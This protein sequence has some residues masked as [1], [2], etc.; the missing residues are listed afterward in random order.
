MFSILFI[1]FVRYTRYYLIIIVLLFSS[2]FEL[3]EYTKANST[4]KNVCVNKSFTSFEIGLSFEY[5]QCSEYGEIYILEYNKGIYA[6]APNA[7]QYLPKVD[8]LFQIHAKYTDEPPIEAIKRTMFKSIDL[9]EQQVC[10]VKNTYTSPNGVALYTIKDR[11][12]LLDAN[13]KHCKYKAYYLDEGFYF[14]PNKNMFFYVGRYNNEYYS[15][16][17]F[18]ITILHQD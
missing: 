9:D 13:S 17:P 16:D 14:T 5:L 6:Y 18:R 2:S 3:L 12:Y 10:E 8:K 1:K 7:P 15:I 11:N 4:V